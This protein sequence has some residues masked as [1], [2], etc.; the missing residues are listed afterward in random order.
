MRRSYILDAAVRSVFPLLL[1]FSLYLLFAGH[2]QPGGGFA[3]GLAASAALMLVFLAGGAGAVR[4][5]VPIR[6]ASVLG[7]G[8]LL[9]ATV[10]TLPML[11]GAEFMESF[12]W[13]FALPVV[14]EVKL[15]SVLFFDT[16]VYLV[17]AGMTL[18]LLQ[19]FG[20]DEPEVA[21]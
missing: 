21:G 16:G 12:I 14:G 6:G 18:Q 7:A 2:N 11:V 20:R 15:V 4:A 5:R 1:V 17:V 3:G 13:K 10:S 19:A 9:A 8:L